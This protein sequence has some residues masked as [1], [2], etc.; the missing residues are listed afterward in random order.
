MEFF[1]KIFFKKQIECVLS[2]DFDLK[3][4]KAIKLLGEKEDLYQD[5]DAIKFLT[6]N[7]IEQKEATEIVIFL[8]IAFIRHLLT[9]VK[10]DDTYIELTNENKT[11]EK[12]FF[13]TQS[14][15][16][17]WKVTEEY[18]A[19]SPNNETIIRIGGRSAEFNVINPFLNNNPNA[20]LEEIKL[21]K[22][23]IIR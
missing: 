15:K 12:K 20:K 1:K 21:S 6:D 2:S 16:I 4:K 19:N 5:N 11:V 7:N 22:T 10:W 14:Y 23:V 3:V 17:I 9:V 13:D 18:F 8:P